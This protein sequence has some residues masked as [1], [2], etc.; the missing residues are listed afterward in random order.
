MFSDN[1]RYGMGSD[2]KAWLLSSSGLG[3]AP[4]LGSSG[5]PISQGTS[6][7][8]PLPGCLLCMPNFPWPQAKPHYGAG[9]FSSFC[10]PFLLPSRGLA[11][12]P[13][14][15]RRAVLHLGLGWDIYCVPDVSFQNDNKALQVFSGKFCSAI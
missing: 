5:V 15:P 13:R 3:W 1:S 10:L 11:R 8:H 6:E 9:T 14:Q 4:C 2:N 7:F 12:A